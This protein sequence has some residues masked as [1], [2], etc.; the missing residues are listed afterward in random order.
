M[1][2]LK[3]ITRR[4]HLLI[5]VALGIL[6]GMAYSIFRFFPEKKEMED[7]ILEVEKTLSRQKEIDLPGDPQAD[8]DRLKKE[9]RE[10]GEELVRQRAS[11]A[12]LEEKFVPLDSPETLHGL[13]VEISDLARA[14][15]VRVMENKPYEPKLPPAQGVKQSVPDSSGSKGSVYGAGGTPYSRPMRRLEAATSYG[16]FKRFI[17]GL[18]N[19]HWR[20][21]VVEFTVEVAQPAKRGPGGEPLAVT[22]ILAL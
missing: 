10:I 6:I 18:N 22:L 15:G 20:V 14:S 7:L 11:I 9:E 17:R 4:E 1:I 16:G 13:Q 21:T 19:L 12:S 3:K 5:L 8:L 2:N